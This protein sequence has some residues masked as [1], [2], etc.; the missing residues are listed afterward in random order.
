MITFQASYTKA[1]VLCGSTN[2]TTLVQLKEDINIGYK[3]FNNA[4]SRYFTRRQGFASL[5]ANQQYY[6][7]PVDS[8]R[9]GHVSVVWSV[10]YEVPLQQVRSEE[11]WRRMNIVPQSGL[12]T[13]Y[14]VYGS[15]QIGL[16]PKPSQ[17]VTN[18]LR[19]VYQ[20]QDIDLT[21]DDYTTGTVA[22]TS[23]STTVTGSSTVWTSALHSDNY[24]Q[25]TN[26]TDGNWYEVDT[27]AGNTSLTLVTPFAGATVSGVTYKLGQLFIFPGEYD[28]VPVDYALSRYFE[29]QNNPERAQYHLGR[30]SQAVDDAVQKYASSSIS[31]V[32]T[33]ENEY[34]NPWLIPPLP[35]V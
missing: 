8:I 32:I 3:R 26:G 35:G 31:S 18:G 7:T 28:D 34:L 9:V 1:Q 16:W 6:Q 30:F 23:G 14:F 19:Y 5:A 2:A 22:I 17:A 13:H 10:N 21:K 4:L 29:A 20:P 15:N 24:L 25:V 27:V 11:E 12:P 33:D